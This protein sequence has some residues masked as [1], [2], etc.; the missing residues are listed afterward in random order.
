VE[1]DLPTPAL[2]VDLNK[3]EQN[4]RSMQTKVSQERC[5]LRPHFKTHKS[6]SLARRQL[7]L[8]A[9]GMSV[10]QLDEAEVLA[11][12][13]ITDILIGNEVVGADK[14]RRVQ[15]L[16]R[17]ASLRMCVDSEAVARFVSDQASGSDTVI[18]VLVDVDA[19]LGRTGIAPERATAFAKQITGLPG[20]RLDG[21]FAYGGNPW[22]GDD[23]QA[24]RETALAEAR[25]AVG[26]ASEFRDAG[27]DC[28]VVSV[29]GT[30]AAS[31]AAEVEGVTEVRPGA[32]L[33]YDSFYANRRVV[34]AD[35]CALTV[36]A[37][38]INRPSADRAILN[39]GSKVLTTE[40]I[41]RGPDG[42]NAEIFPDLPDARVL[43][44]WEEHA[45]I[46]ISPDQSLA[47]GDVV[48]LIPAHG[49][50]VINLAD[51]LFGVRN[52]VVAEVISIDARA[53]PSQKI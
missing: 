48:R 16:A 47:V 12:N 51:Q 20:L 3:M 22:T 6:I 40:G 34:T 23:Q 30:P 7:E 39:S 1:A 45:V 43:K 27:I 52:G 53:Y 29:A 38:V 21:V 13:G 44:L 49:C 42:K 32:Y 36:R 31:I 15:A 35:Q 4:L 28:S 5:Q 24:R 9:C 46:E 17:I 37:T 10:S 8:G 11:A 50:P 14:A 33:F 19:G 26:V 18:G 25:L 2:V 41:G